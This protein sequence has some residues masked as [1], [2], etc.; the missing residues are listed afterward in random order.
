MQQSLKRK[1]W[2]LKMAE[3]QKQKRLTNQVAHMRAEKAREHQVSD[4]GPMALAQE[5]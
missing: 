4:L 3:K 5:N 2:D 1:S